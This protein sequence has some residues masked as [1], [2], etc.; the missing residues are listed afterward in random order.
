MTS[1]VLEEIRERIVEKLPENI[2]LAK[3]EFEGPEVVIYTK[4]HE[5]IADSG[6]IIRTLAKDLRKRI[7]IRSDKSVLMEPDDTIKAVEEIVPIEAEIT[8]ISFDDIAIFFVKALITK[9]KHL[10]TSFCA[11]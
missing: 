4:N 1:N 5:M 2:Q 11:M 8:N 10:I 7:I 3:I 6:D 9:S